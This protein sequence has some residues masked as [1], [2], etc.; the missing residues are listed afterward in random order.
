[1]NKQGWYLAAA[2]GF[3]VQVQGQQEGWW[4]RE[5]VRLLQTNLRETDAALDAQRLID[6][7]VGFKANVLLIGMGGITAYYPT[8]VK[9][10]FA[11]PYLPAGRD[12]F[13]EVLRLAHQRQIRVIGRFDLSKTRKEVYDA[14]PDWFYKRA[15]GDP[16]VYNGLY[17]VCINGGYYST[18]AMEILAE[19]LERYE[20]DGLFFNMF[21]NQM[22][23]YSGQYVGPCHC[24]NCKRE[25]RRQ[26]GRE[27]PERPDEVYQA[28]LHAS[29]L[30]VA[31][32]I[33]KLIRNK[34]PQAG[35]FNYIQEFTDGIMSESNTAVRRPLPLWPYASSDHVNR[36]RNS[37]PGKA[38]V[39]L[40]MSF[41]D[42]PWRFATVPPNEIRLRLWQNVAHG[43][44]AAIN[45]HGTLDQEDLSAVGAARGVYWWLAEH[46]EYF[47]GQES[48]AKV[49][50]LGRPPAAPAPEN[51]YR[52]M[53]RLLSEEHIPFAVSD[54][55]DWIGKR[56]FDLVITTGWI[57]KE[58][59]EWTR[60]GGRLLIAA[61]SET[62]LDLGRVIRKW[63]GVQGYFRVR[64]HALF[65]S[66]KATNLLM[67]NG[68]YVETAS[69]SPLT[70]IPPSMFGP[71]EKV[72]V[73]WKDTDSPGLILRDYGK[74]RVAWVPWD[75]GGLYYLHSSMA[76][77]GLLRDLVD[78]LLP[79]GRQIRTN[80]HP[81]VEMSLMRQGKRV[82]L[83]LVN[84]S[85]HSDTA[86]FDPV[87]MNDIEISV[88]GTY[89]S[90]RLVR[91]NAQIRV[92]LPVDQRTRFTVPRLGAYELVELQGSGL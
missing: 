67:L 60:G 88:A 16:V 7:L 85:G 35:F 17:S 40:C 69:A 8:L 59:D 50:L 54:N 74:G 58:L 64:D 18:K 33:G 5:P 72:H 55:L 46:Q 4:M 86:Y 56:P 37:Q 27:I 19:A 42:F 61:A 53:F 75:A 91:S 81:L 92:R 76:H 22:T 30:R 82:L 70:L 29:R 63:T 32:R 51:S 24:D 13:G 31:E 3:A 87:P 39:N 48:A 77:H 89:T 21:G 15:S 36:A 83:H 71:P 28:F 6:G 34:R 9:D 1:M 84:L 62:P 47:A 38:A 23:D 14:H 26:H 44:A 80:A 68:D 11:S 20:V 52:G 45:M 49:L 66:L 79:N 25:F 12:M 43:G 65:P 41:I 73:D 90:V 10:H 78:H 57:P 2:L